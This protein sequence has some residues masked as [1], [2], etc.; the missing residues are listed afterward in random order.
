MEVNTV[1]TGILCAFLLGAGWT[2]LVWGKVY[3]LWLCLAAL[4]GLALG[5]ADFLTGALAMMI[6][7]FLLFRFR[8]MGAGDGKITAV[9]IGY[10][11]LEEGIQAIGGG[12]CVGAVWS[13]W[14]LYCD[15]SL[16]VRFRYP[17]EYVMC[18]LMERRIL[19]YDELYAADGHHRIPL[20]A[21]LAVGVCLYLAG[22]AVWM[23]GRFL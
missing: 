9:I 8:L 22:R 14:R 13:L 18:M 5:G 7:A 1:K 4:A 17:L 19:A 23:G 12:L 21:C 2:D 6:P 16:T 20:A 3:N 10:L 15:G 11:G